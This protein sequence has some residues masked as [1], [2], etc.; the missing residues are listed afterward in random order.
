MYLHS[1]PPPA[2]PQDWRFNQQP[3]GFFAP[4]LTAPYGSDALHHA[5]R[6]VVIKEQARGELIHYME[7][8]MHSTQL[9]SSFAFCCKRGYYH[10]EA[11]NVVELLTPLYHEV[12]RG[13]A[14]LPYDDVA[15]LTSSLQ[16]A[17][18]GGDPQSDLAVH[19]H[20]AK[21]AAYVDG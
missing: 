5:S 19:S 17:A 1:A 7:A 4:Y 10:Q 18:Q 8:N 13:G 20:H 15:M 21:L 11:Y 6:D 12:M 3:P 16:D 2:S 14:D 9:P